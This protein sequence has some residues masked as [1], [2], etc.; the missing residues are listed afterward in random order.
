MGVQRQDAECDLPELPEENNHTGETTWKT[1]AQ[2]QVRQP[3]KKQSN[4]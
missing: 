3:A 2:Q 4:F 1:T